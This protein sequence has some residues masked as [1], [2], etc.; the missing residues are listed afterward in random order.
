MLTDKIVKC[1][2]NMLT[3]NERSSLS[4]HPQRLLILKNIY[5]FIWL[6]R[7]LVAAHGIFVAARRIFCCGVWAL[8]CGTW[9]SL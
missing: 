5:L 2:R 8:H 6:C 7:V 3:E 9:A 4:V 1:Y